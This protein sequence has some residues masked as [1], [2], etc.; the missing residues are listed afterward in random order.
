[1]AAFPFT[2]GSGNIHVLQLPASNSSQ[3]LNCSCSP[4][5]SLTH[6]PTHSTSLN[7]LHWLTVYNISAW[8]AQ[9]TPFQQ[10]FYSCVTQLS[11]RL[12]REH[13]F[14]VSPLVC[15]SNLLPSNGHCLQSHYL[16]MGPHATVCLRVKI[17]ACI[18][19][20][21]HEELFVARKHCLIP[22]S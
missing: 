13:R 17:R 18:L 8:A 2:L 19:F 14:Q 6:Q 11:H 3:G 15:V 20:I 10:F 21:Q 4:T 5:N 12:C 1:M 22:G 9:K 16:A 7:W